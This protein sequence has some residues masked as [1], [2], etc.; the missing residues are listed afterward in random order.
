MTTNTLSLDQLLPRRW[1]SNP[2]RL[3]GPL[4]EGHGDGEGVHL[5][6]QSSGARP[7][8]ESLQASFDGLFVKNSVQAA[9]NSPQPECL[10]DLLEDARCLGQGLISDQARLEEY[11]Q[12]VREAELRVQKARQWMNTPFFSPKGSPIWKFLLIN[13]SLSTE[14]VRV[15]CSGFSD[16]SI[17]G[18]YQIG[19]ARVGSVIDF[20]GD[21]FS[22]AH[23]LSHE[24]KQLDG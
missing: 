17:R 12:S 21:R 8:G 20:T 2:A 15:D 3:I 11:L 22:A 14:Y 5:V 7:R 23:Q 18:T 13:H 16:R 10:D 9:H 19:R 6:L 24:T 1:G 4:D